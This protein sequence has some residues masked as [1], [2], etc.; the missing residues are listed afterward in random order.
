MSDIRID[1]PGI[2]FEKLNEELR[3]G[4]GETVYGGSSYHAGVL[5]VHLTAEAADADANSARLIV[6]GHDARQKTA[7][8]KAAEEKV[9]ALERLCKMD[10]DMW[11]EATVEEQTVVMWQV[12]KDIQSILGG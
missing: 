2:N 4:L 6:A 8:Q 9:A 5:I 12:L 10:M 1:A 7:A 11:A 3:T